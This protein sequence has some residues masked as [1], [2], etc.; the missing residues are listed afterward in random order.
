[1]SA[2]VIDVGYE[3]EDLYDS[4]FEDSTNGGKLGSHYDLGGS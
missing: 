1:V 2:L 4:I 3:S